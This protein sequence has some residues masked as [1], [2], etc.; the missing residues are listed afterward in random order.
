MTYGREFYFDKNGNWDPTIIPKYEA[1]QYAKEKKNKEFIT[2]PVE[3]PIPFIHGDEDK[4]PIY[5]SKD[6]YVK[7]KKKQIK[8]NAKE[9]KIVQIE[10]MQCLAK[11]DRLLAKLATLDPAKK[12]DSKKIVNINIKLKDLDLEIDALQREVGTDLNSLNH[13]SKFQRKWETF[14][15]RVRKRFKKIKRWFKDNKELVLGIAAIVIPGILSLIFGKL[16]FNVAAAA[17]I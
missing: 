11:R 3:I 14:K 6:W 10:I 16:G 4:G 13:G 17:A 1:E 12:K 8:R 15:K 7:K 5:V 2:K 9:S